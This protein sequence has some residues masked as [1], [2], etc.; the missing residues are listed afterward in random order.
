M[1]K[2]KNISYEINVDEVIQQ[3]TLMADWRLY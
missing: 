3:K 2:G 1:V